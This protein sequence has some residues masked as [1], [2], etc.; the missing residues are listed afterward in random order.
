MPDSKMPTNPLEDAKILR[1]VLDA[2]PMSA[3]WKDRDGRYVGG[4]AQFAKDCNVAT[5]E[6][7]IGKT[8]YDLAWTKEEADFFVATDRRIMSSGKGEYHILEP[9]SRADGTTVWL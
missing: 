9:Q 6:E 4:N 2:L 5:C 7:L 3:F 1:A 8:D